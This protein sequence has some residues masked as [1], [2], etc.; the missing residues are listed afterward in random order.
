MGEQSDAK[1][2]A[3]ETAGNQALAD[4][5]APPEYRASG[6][7]AMEAS[8]PIS[9]EG[10]GGK[11]QQT[12]INAGLPAYEAAPNEKNAQL[13]ALL[14]QGIGKDKIGKQAMRGLGFGLDDEEYSTTPQYDQTGRGFVQSKRGN[15][16]YLDGITARDKMEVQGNNVY[17]PYAVTAGTRLPDTLS[18]ERMEQNA[19]IASRGAPRTQVTVNPE[20]PFATGMAGGAVDILKASNEAAR[21]AADVIRSATDIRHAL[22]T[23]L[24]SGGPGASAAQSFRQIFG[25]DQKK[26]DA[27][28]TVIQNSAKIALASRGKLKGQ[29]SVTE[30]EQALLIRADSPDIDNMSTGEI[31]QVTNIADRLSRIAIQ[32]NRLNVERASKIPGGENIVGFYNVDEPPQYAPRKPQGAAGAPVKIS[33]DADFA[34][35]PSGAQ[36]VGPDG[37]ARRKP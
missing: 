15:T 35:L 24:V 18:P 17:N 11:P 19:S 26:M 31:R 3:K 5:I 10:I 1:A 8:A 2:L 12:T 29:G 13:V 20:N 23:G 34:K 25:G 37:V 21:G 16:K 28:R 14:N 7:N 32:Q 27:T 22:D 4:V 36:F 33:G 30:P 9:F 6:Q